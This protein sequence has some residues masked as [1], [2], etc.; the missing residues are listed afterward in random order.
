MGD[1]PCRF[2]PKG[3]VPAFG[4][5]RRLHHSGYRSMV[6]PKHGSGLPRPVLSCLLLF[7]LALTGANALARA[8]DPAAVRDGYEYY[9]VGDL[10]AARP[11]NTEPALM[12]MGDRKST[13][14]NSSHYYA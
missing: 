9:R 5:S 11:G 3:G 12:L 6:L 8:P 14:L 7:C 2:V 10:Q 4:A 13:R 1:K